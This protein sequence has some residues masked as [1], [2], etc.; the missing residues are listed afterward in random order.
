MKKK[1]L[2]TMLAL[3][4]V[5]PML[6]MGV[7]ATEEVSETSELTTTEPESEEQKMPEDA[8][9]SDVLEPITESRK[10]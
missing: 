4:I 8:P 2:S 10:Q 5:L 6:P 9:L 7:L 1:L 3:C